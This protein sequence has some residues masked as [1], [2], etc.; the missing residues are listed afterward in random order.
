MIGAVVENIIGGYL[1]PRASVRRLLDAGHGVDVALLMVVLAYLVVT[2]FAI[3]VPGGRS[4]AGGVQIS[5]YFFGLLANLVTFCLVTALVLKIGRLFG[6]K[7]TWSETGLAMA[8][9]IL[10]TSM[11]EPMTLP[12]R[13]HL[14]GLMA[15]AAGDGPV[16][17]IA[18]P[19]GYLVMFMAASAVMLW[20]FACY[21]AELHRFARTWKVLAVVVGLSGA[22]S[23]ALTAV[24]PLP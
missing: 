13:I 4:P 19:A 17:A 10:V 3:L 6:G 2:I 8:W 5:L 16:E 24:V 11:I 15:G 1:H 14:T 21:V 12:A 23:L 22:F 20:L 7:G 9:F 18:L